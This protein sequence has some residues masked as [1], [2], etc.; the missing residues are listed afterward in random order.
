VACRQAA[1][2][3]DYKDAVALQTDPDLEALRTDPAFQKVINEVK[4]R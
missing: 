2:G 3:E 4:A 1:A